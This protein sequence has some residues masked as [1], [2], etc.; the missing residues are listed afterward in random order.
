MKNN[1]FVNSSGMVDEVWPN[2]SLRRHLN[3][4]LCLAVEFNEDFPE[5]CPDFLLS[6]EHGKVLV[7]TREP[8]PKGSKVR[9]HFYIPPDSK[10]LGI[11]EGK[12]V[13]HHQNKT[14]EEMA[15]QI[16]ILDQSKNKMDLFKN[17]LEEKKQLIDI[18][19]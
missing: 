2:Y 6:P 19:A 5:I 10:R 18:M 8:L 3:F 1:I 13:D 14:T 16:K 15:M 7:K 17:Y 4:P 12:V 11:F 9:M